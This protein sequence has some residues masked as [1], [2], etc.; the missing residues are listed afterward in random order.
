MG[1]VTTT[2]GSLEDEVV[3]FWEGAELRATDGSDV[4]TPIGS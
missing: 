4:G 2:D 1:M 3:G